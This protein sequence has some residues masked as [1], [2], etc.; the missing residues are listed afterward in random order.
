[1]ARSSFAKLQRDRD[2]KAKAAAK[3]ERRQGRSSEEE[4]PDDEQAAAPV[5]DTPTEDL[6]A[7]IAELHERFEAHEID[8]ETFEEQK[9]S[10]MARLSV[11]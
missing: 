4:A 10:L 2:K 9:A 11:D 6:L 8:F 1:M 7:Q 3:R 5:D